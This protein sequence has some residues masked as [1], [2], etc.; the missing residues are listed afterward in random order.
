MPETSGAPPLDIALANHL[1][2]RFENK[3][4]STASVPAADL[5]NGDHEAPGTFGLEVDWIKGATGVCMCSVWSFHTF[6]W[7][8]GRLN[9]LLRRLGCCH[10]CHKGGAEVLGDG[11]KA[12]CPCSVQQT[13]PV[14]IPSASFTGIGRPL[15]TNA[16]LNLIIGVPY[17]AIKT[18]VSPRKTVSHTLAREGVPYV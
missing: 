3:G 2:L 7:C 6:A 13:C 5:P 17:T 10:W 11:V 16:R 14:L 12:A 18:I 9:S 8:S 4:R 15:Q 1:A